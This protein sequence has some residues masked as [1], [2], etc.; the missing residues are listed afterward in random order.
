M[1][2]NACIKPYVNVSVHEYVFNYLSKTYANVIIWLYLQ[3]FI[4]TSNF[5]I[6]LDI[7]GTISIMVLFG[8]CG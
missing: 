4:T 5:D 8:Y 1:L 6:V 2:Q 3:S 7:P